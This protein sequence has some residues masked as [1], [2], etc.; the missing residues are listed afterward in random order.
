MRHNIKHSRSVSVRKLFTKGR[1]ICFMPPLLRKSDQT[2]L[3]PHFQGQSPPISRI[4][5]AY[6]YFQLALKA[7]WLLA[8]FSL[9][10][11]CKKKDSPPPEGYRQ[12][13]RNFV[14]KISDYAKS[15]NPNFVII[16]QNGLEIIRGE[17]GSPAWSYL[18]AID[19]AGCEE[20]LYGYEGDDRPTPEE[21]TTYWKSYLDL[22]KANGKKVLVIDY[23]SSPAHVDSS[24]AK[25]NRFG[26]IS[27]AAHRRE[28][29][30]IPP[31]PPQPFAV[32]AES[33]ATLPQARNFLYL[34]NPSG[35]PSKTAFL[36]ALR[37]TD[38][39]LLIIDLFYQGETL[40][41]E[42]VRSLQVKK[43]G[44]R[45][46]VVSYLSIGEAED[47]R[48]YWRPEWKRKPPAW[49][50]KE[51]P[52]WPGNYKV[53]YWYSEWQDIILD[54]TRRIVET[55]FDGAYLDIID[56]FAYYE[57]K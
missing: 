45:R 20:L 14:K 25:N 41:P 22:L 49:L 46:L 50:D 5:T 40:T 48:Y 3:P 11:S 30:A 6:N 39:D 55:G 23:C 21:I 43:N 54:Y 52:N 36:D 8:A 12:D 47:Y 34:L 9:L 19:G 15:R 38:Y 44:A 17:D 35:F 24:Y 32:N 29:D 18:A 31:Y 57:S 26:Y 10:G 42:E 4:T 56:A 1:Y 28:V 33:I 16:P 53:K 13:M 7:A 27:F 37:N 2:N 51:N